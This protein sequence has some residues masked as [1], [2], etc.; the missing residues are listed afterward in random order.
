[1]FHYLVLKQAEDVL[2]LKSW[3]QRHDKW[4]SDTIQIKSPSCSHEFQK[5]IIGDMEFCEY[6]G[7]VADGSTDISG[8]EQYALCMQFSNNLRLTNLSMYNS[9]DSTGETLAR[10]IKD[11]LLR[12]NLSLDTDRCHVRW[13]LQ[14]ERQA[15]RSPG[16]S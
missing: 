3:L 15:Q 16:H 12:L 8:D 4:M 2:E 11:M 6:F 1:M 9:L 5:L 13:S 10:A 7:I 14:H